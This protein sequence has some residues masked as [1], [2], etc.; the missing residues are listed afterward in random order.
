M[1]MDKT[2][3]MIMPPSVALTFHYSGKPICSVPVF[4]LV[5]LAREQ[6]Q[7][8][9]RNNL[10]NALDVAPDHIA[11]NQDPQ[12]QAPYISFLQRV[13]PYRSL[14]PYVSCPSYLRDTF[15]M[16]WSDHIAQHESFSFQFISVAMPDMVYRYIRFHPERV[17]DLLRDGKLFMPCPAMF[18]DPFDCSLDEPTRLTFIERAIGCFST[19]PDDVLMFS[20]YADNHRGLCVGFN[21]RLLVQSLTSKNAPLRADIRPVWYFSTMPNLSLVTQP[22]LCATC[23]HDIWAYEHEFRIFMAKGSSLA[24]SA[25]FAFDRA[26]ISEVICGC[27][28]SDD[29]VAV[30]K[31][32]T[33]DLSSCTQKKALQ[34]PNHFGVQLHTIHKI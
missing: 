26:A 6:A 16:M 7:I 22:A 13:I 31:T 12:S 8:P 32:L 27:K 3:N 10:L 28:A 25:L 20:H 18:N 24:P 9:D 15:T 2:D 11:E 19:V 30:C 29:T 23:K 5:L 33:N 4:L 34:L 14:I 17:G 1:E 21:T